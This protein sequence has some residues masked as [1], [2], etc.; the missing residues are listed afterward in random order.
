[1]TGNPAPMPKQ[2]MSW[3]GWGQEILS[4]AEEYHV[5]T[6]KAVSDPGGISRS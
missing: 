6:A 4:R 2:P 5:V 1:M 3:K